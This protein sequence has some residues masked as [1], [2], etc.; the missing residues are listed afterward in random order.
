MQAHMCRCHLWHVQLNHEPPMCKGAGLGT[1]CWHAP[2]TSS[3]T[4]TPP[5]PVELWYSWCQNESGCDVPG[6]AA[7]HSAAD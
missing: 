1:M 6:Y 4:A 3:C 2:K 5:V 7:D